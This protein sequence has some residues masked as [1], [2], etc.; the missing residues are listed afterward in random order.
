[1][2][3]DGPTSDQ[4]AVLRLAPYRLRVMPGTVMTE[5]QGR[6]AALGNAVTTTSPDIRALP[7]APRN[8]LPLWRLVTLVRSLD[9]GQ[10]V[11]RDAGG[12]VTRIQL[13]PKRLVPPIVA[14][15]SPAGDA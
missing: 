12:P 10:E 15:M 3:K 13:G 9:T 6:G 14:V 11:I 1:M 8:P 4:F 2:W 7:L 5:G